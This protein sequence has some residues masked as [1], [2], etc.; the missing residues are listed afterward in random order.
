MLPTFS[1]FLHKFSPYLRIFNRYKS[2]T[3]K[4]SL[5]IEGK[6]VLLYSGKLVWEKDLKTL[7]D[8]YNILSV[9]RDD[10]VFVLVGEGPIKNELQKLMPKAIFL[11]Y[12]SGHALSTI[13]SS[14]DIFV[15]PST[16]EIFGNV[17]LSK[18]WLPEFHRYAHGKEGHREL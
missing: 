12:Q 5:G 11:G 18:Q 9:Y 3:W 7:T 4:K 1:F 17:T 2:S 14:S 10:F 8:T 16:T 15:F 13:Y 6:T